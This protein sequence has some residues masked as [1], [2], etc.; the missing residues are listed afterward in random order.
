MGHQTVTLNF[1]TDVLTDPLGSADVQCRS[2]GEIDRLN[3]GGIGCWS[4]T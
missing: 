1:G 2:T 3:T 4:A